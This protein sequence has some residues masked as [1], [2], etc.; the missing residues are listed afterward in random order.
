MKLTILGSG[1][2]KS[3]VK[4]NPSG[5]LLEKGKQ[6]L[7]LDIGPG[8]IR[9]LKYSKINLLSIRAL[10]ISHFH[11]DH[12]SDL[13]PFLMNRYLLQNDSNS[14]L[15]II[16]PKDLKVWFQDQARW[17]GHWLHNHLPLLME[18]ND[19]MLEHGD[20]QIKAVLNGH[21]YNS[22]SF[23]IKNSQKDATLFYSSD[24]DYNAALL[25]LAQKAHWGL[26]ECSLPDHLKQ[27]GHLTASETGQFAAAAGFDYLIVTHIYP[28]NDTWDL[29][30]RVQAHFTGK[31]M[32]AQDLEQWEIE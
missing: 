17:Q 18:W 28:E 32:V 26:V 22:L 15:T 25:P 9:Q 19:K 24:T 2:M 6:M 3:P 30:Q 1:T 13:L 31:V 29:Q 8:I 7:L 23:L 11:P 16:G 20:W 14:Q 5:Y 21:T 10:A 12:C 4:R 27:K